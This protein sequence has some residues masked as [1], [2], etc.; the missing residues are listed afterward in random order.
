MDFNYWIHSLNEKQ[1]LY[2]APKNTLT[3]GLEQELKR[4]GITVQGFIDNFKSDKDC[5]QANSVT[6]RSNIL[7]FSP[8]YWQEIA[9]SLTIHQRFI[10]HI[11]EIGETISTLE[12]FTEYDEQYQFNSL[13]TQKSYW[14][15][16]LQDHISKKSSM[17][18]YGYEWGD[19]EN[20]KDP[21]GNYLAILNKVKHY[22]KNSNHSLELGTLGGKWTKYLLASKRVTCVDINPIMI[23]AIK[24]RYPDNLHQIDFYVTSGSELTDVKSGSID[25]LFCIDTLVR[26]SSSIILDYVKEI[27]RVLSSNGTALIHFPSKHINGS[28]ERNFTAFDHNEI[29]TIY[30]DVFERINIDL[31][32]LQ[33]GAL[34]TL[35]KGN[36]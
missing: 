36:D 2:I 13:L 4:H 25:F 35:L 27:S 20:A 17:E 5:I 30:H 6:Q 7:I 26:S 19:P 1:A 22:A 24:N 3:I 11:S 21:L 12:E 23:D 9:H 34:V 16:H 32:T 8:N 31:T 14:S 10:F 29:Q 15:T 33:H 18:K 28:V